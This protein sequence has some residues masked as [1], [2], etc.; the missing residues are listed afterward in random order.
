MW[1]NP[2]RSPSSHLSSE[3]GYLYHATNIDG[4]GD[5]ATSGSLRTHKPWHGTDQ[6]AWPDGSKEKRSYWSP[7]ADVV[8]QFAPD[9]GKGVVLRV[10]RDAAAFKR[11]GTGDVYAT[12]PIPAK[13]LEILDE[14]GSWKPLK[15]YSEWRNPPLQ[16][17]ALLVA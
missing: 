8:W 1:S 15:G 5:I 11:E 7:K 17:G 3:D 4:A 12:K 14:D 16:L 6:D 2:P 10:K 9:E 13:Q